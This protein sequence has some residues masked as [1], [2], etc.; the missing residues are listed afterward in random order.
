MDPSFLAAAFRHRRDAGILLECIGGGVALP[1][2][3]EGDKEAR[4]K[5]RPGARQG[6]KQREVGMALGA[7][8]NGMVEVGDREQEAP[9]LSDESL[10]QES[11]RGNNTLI[12]RQWYCVLA[13][14]DACSDDVG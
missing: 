5:D 1:L 12:S 7:L 4:G 6:S 2:F 14:L 8:R 3:A 9:E 10:D 13:G 11:M